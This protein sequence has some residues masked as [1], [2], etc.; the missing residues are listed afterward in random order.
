[1]EYDIEPL[2]VEMI[3]NQADFNGKVVLEIGC[4]GGE[5]SSLLANDT[6]QYI[7]IDPDI[8]AINDASQAYHNVDFRIGMV[9]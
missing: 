2:T 8:S 1:M 5:I 4:G 6:E 7:G 3:K 9:I